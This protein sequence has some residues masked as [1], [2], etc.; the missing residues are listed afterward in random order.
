M[1]RPITFQNGNAV[2]EI[3]SRISAVPRSSGNEREITE[4]VVARALGQG[5][6]HS[7]DDA[8][9]I[10]V[11]VPASPG[12]ESLPPIILQSHLDMVC[13]KIPGSSHDFTSDPIHLVV[14][15]DW[16]RADGTTLGADNGIG[17]A[18]GLA[19]AEE[20][21]ARRPALELLFT[22]E[23]ETGL[24]GAQNLDTGMLRGRTLIN[25][26]SEEEGALIIG[27]AGGENGR[28]SLPVTREDI[29]SSHALYQLAVSGLK[30]GHSGMNIGEN[31]GNANKI[32]ARVLEAL[33][34]EVSLQLVTVEGGSRSNVIPRDAMAIFA[35]PQNTTEKARQLTQMTAKNCDGGVCCHRKKP[36]HHPDPLQPSGFHGKGCFCDGQPPLHTPPEQPSP[37]RTSLVG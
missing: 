32:L 17:M 7:K 4:W 37:R 18:I 12:H 29:P 14:D 10:V 19:L 11:R 20:R 35:L 34:S 3:F 2:L 24:S 15:G 25:I 30:G 22:V 28:I 13:E 6:D 1:N 36:F 26:D 16:L 33:M 31:R 27:C 9:N 21:S 8:G 23:E 5:F